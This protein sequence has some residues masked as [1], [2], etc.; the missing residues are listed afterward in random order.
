[1]RVRLPNGKTYIAYWPGEPKGYVPHL[2]ADECAR[3]V[4]YEAMR[5]AAKRGRQSQAEKGISDGTIFGLIK[6]SKVT[7]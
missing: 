7:A 3:R 6:Q 1:M 5:A 2:A 4:N